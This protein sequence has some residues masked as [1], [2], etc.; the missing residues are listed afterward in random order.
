MIRCL[1][2]QNYKDAVTF[3]P[4]RGRDVMACS[5]CERY[6]YKHVGLQLVLDKNGAHEFSYPRD[7]GGFG[8]RM[9]KSWSWYFGHDLGAMM[10]IPLLVWYNKE[11]YQYHSCAEYMS[12]FEKFSEGNGNGEIYLNDVYR[13]DVPDCESDF[14]I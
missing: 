2:I 11:F 10:L 5:L 3:L 8:S 6:T 4:D 9:L 13:E 7:D 12:R 14:G 1:R